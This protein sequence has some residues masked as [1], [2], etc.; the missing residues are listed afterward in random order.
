MAIKDGAGLQGA[1]SIMIWYRHTHAYVQRQTEED[2]RSH[3][4]CC[5]DNAASAAQ[6]LGSSLGPSRVCAVASR[7]FSFDPDWLE[8]QIA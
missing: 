3:V 7:V 5:D 8:D 4:V 6:Q 1:F 2:A